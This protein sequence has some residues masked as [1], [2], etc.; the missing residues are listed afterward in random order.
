MV[1]QDHRGVKRVTRPMLGFTA[2]AA[3]QDTLTEIERRHRMKNRQLVVAEG[4]A[5]LTAAEQFAAL[6][7]ESSH[8]PRPRPASHLHTKICDRA[9]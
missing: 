2:V 9:P 6:A 7:A 5:G 1:E 3:A 8:R 4:D